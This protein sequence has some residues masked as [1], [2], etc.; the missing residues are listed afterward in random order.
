MRVNELA[1]YVNVLLRSRGETIEYSP[2]EI[3]WKLRTLGINKHSSRAGRQILFG[4][5]TSQGVHRLARAYDLS[6]SR[7]VEV[8]C[9]DCNQ[10]EVTISK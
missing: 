2:E 10:S 6:C 4:R 1:K 3:G 9:P 7:L 8:G 5:D